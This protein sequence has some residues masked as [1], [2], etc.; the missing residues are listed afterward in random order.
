MSDTE[1]RNRK[2]N[3]SK[4]KTAKEAAKPEIDQRDEVMFI[5]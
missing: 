5:Q 3:R 2:V 4:N 1:V